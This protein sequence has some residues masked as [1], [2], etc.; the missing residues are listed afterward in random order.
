[1][2]VSPSAVEPIRVNDR[3][4][5]RLGDHCVEVDAATWHA[6][7]MRALNYDWSGDSSSTPASAA[8]SAA[9]EVA[10]DLL[11][12]SGESSADELASSSDAQF[13]RRLNVVTGEGLLTNAGVL[14]FVGRGSPSLDYM[15]R[16]YAGGDST[17]RVRRSDR[18]LLEELAEVFLTMDAHNANRHLPSGLVV[19]Q[20]RDIPVLAA[21][22][23]VVNGVA[24]R[25]WGIA[26]PTVVEQVGRSLVVTSPGGFF[27]GVNESNII[28]H[29]SQSVARRSG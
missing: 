12:A 4:L 29:P 25:E 27:G 28:T 14:A 8:R 5:W 26:E 2:L 23:A 1:M 10:R 24:H 9:L 11:R 22:E 7:R 19:R 20:V 16:D 21:R 17:A 6:R 15:H 13:L 3:I 18:S